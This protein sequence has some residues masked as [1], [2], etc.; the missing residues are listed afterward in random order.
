MNSSG[1]M[2]SFLHFPLWRR[3]VFVISLTAVILAL[4]FLWF[5]GEKQHRLQQRDRLHDLQMLLA[6][7]V[8]A[9]AQAN[10]TE[11]PELD[12]SL[13]LKSFRSNNSAKDYVLR[14]AFS[15]LFHWLRQLSDSQWYPQLADWRWQGNMIELNLS[16]VAN[17]HKVTEMP[18][19]VSNPFPRL[20]PAPA[21]PLP[22]CLE[23]W[24][25]TITLAA[26]IGSRLALSDGENWQQ[27]RQ[28]EVHRSSGLVFTNV[29]NGEVTLSSAVV[30]EQSEWPANGELSEQY[31]IGE[32]LSARLHV[33]DEGNEKRVQQP[34]WLP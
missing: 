3:I 22:S 5:D 11:L 26:T 27:Y 28:G 12:D 34:R 14:G 8:N 13:D 9:A 31:P 30:Q 24:P 19:V 1:E 33:R 29:D 21:K 15:D 25:E 2:F 16:L 4:K 32:C 6:V 10:N 17:A 7:P 23:L 20:I 18:G